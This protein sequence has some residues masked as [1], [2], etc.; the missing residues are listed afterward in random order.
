MRERKYVKLR[1]DMYDDTKSKIIDAMEERD[2][3]HYIWTRL[4]TLAGKVNLEGNLYM[5]KNIPYTVETLSIEFN[6]SVEKVILALKALK[7][8]EM[9]EC[10]E[11]GC[12]RVRN[13]AKH[14]NIKVKDEKKNLA[15][16][17]DENIKGEEDI[18][19]DMCEKS[20][21]KSKKDKKKKIENNYEN[22]SNINQV[23][24]V[25]EENVNLKNKP[26]KSSKIIDFNNNKN[27]SVDDE[28]IGG[29]ECNAKE[30]L[31]SNSNLNMP[32]LLQEKKARKEKPPSKKRNGKNDIVVID[33]EDDEIMGFFNGE[34][35][36]KRK[37]EELIRSF[38]F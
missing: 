25:N 9:I 15:V 12:Y 4:L 16:N 33:G 26:N 18:I 30:K 29:N 14:Q 2:V 20:N 38:Q 23:K 36:P 8:L 32:M 3:I 5:S 13:F 19:N 21:Q 24:T 28:S 17:E 7:D 1:V 6:R 37:G 27:I 35:I 34:E 11:E 10:N 22:Y 31:D